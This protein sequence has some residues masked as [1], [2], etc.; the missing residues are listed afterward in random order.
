MGLF[1]DKKS[2]LPVRLEGREPLTGTI[3]KDYSYM[4]GVP[5]QQQDINDVEQ[6]FKR[7]KS[8][9]EIEVMAK[10]TAEKPCVVVKYKKEEYSI[11]FHVT[12]FDIPE[13]Y[14]INHLLDDESK[15]IIQDNKRG[16]CLNMTFGTDNVVSYHLQLKMLNIMIP[17]L[18]AIV[19]FSCEK[20]FSGKWAKL[21][22]QSKVPP[23]PLYLYTVQAVSGK[24]D[25]VWLHTHGLNRCGGVELEIINSN[26]K[27]CDNHY[28]VLMALAGR[29]VDKSGFINENE[30]MYIALLS[31][32]IEL[33]ATWVDWK[34]VMPN[35][36][37][38]AL[39]GLLDRKDE[40]HNGQTGIVYL[41]ASEED[42]NNEIFSPVSIY[43]ENLADN[44][45]IMYSNEETN[46]MK[47]LAAERLYV[48]K[49]CVKNQGAEALIKVGLNQDAKYEME[50]DFH[51][52]IW[53]RLLELKENSF[54]AELTQEPYYVD[55]LNA[56]DTRELRYDDIT[57]WM[58]FVDEQRIT[59]DTVYLVL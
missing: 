17:D 56:G 9:D 38:R 47:A 7:I 55:N 15:K 8:N 22:A 36:E 34:R 23:S 57:D 32:N 20:I 48:L 54:I 35:L 52:H 19:D 42:Y 16:L 18:I 41:Y 28:N 4:L 27:N 29:I 11:E 59:P 58:M 6:L 37:K 40:G 49:D 44:P 12:T 53:F 45:L 1:G 21:A 14:T 50:E 31:K 24:K 46:R 13:L 39:G 25:K 26:K 30:S 5:R 10:S 33:V 3:P 43:D 51:E 2:K